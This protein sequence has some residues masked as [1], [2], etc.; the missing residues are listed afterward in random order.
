MG[1]PEIITEWVEGILDVPTEYGEFPPTKGPRAMVKAA[2]GDPVVK[3]Y[4]SGGG[5]YRFVY[6]VYLLV[7]G[8]TE[9]KRLDGMERLKALADKISL[10]R[11]VPDDDGAPTWNA[12][13]VTA[14]PNLFSRKGEESIY[15]L[16]ASIAYI[17]RG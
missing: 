13:G 11:E 3:E 6:E 9:A 10:D 7:P 17:V 14:L 5:I 15:Q 2:P 12:H 4:Q 1:V 8:A 16:V